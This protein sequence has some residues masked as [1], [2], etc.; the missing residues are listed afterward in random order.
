MHIH[1]YLQF[2]HAKSRVKMSQTNTPELFTSVANSF[3]VSMQGDGLRLPTFDEVLE[4]HAART[5]VAAESV[6]STA[7]AA[8]SASSTAAAAE[9]ASSTAPAVPCTRPKSRPQSTQAKRLRIMSKTSIDFYPLQNEGD[10][11]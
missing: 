8:E 5:A 4:Q 1:Q 7:A 10:D 2:P 11:A 9:S 6:S 3:V